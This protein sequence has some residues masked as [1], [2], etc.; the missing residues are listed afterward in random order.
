M[1]HFC[2]K[3]IELQCPG[4]IKPDRPDLHCLQRRIVSDSQNQPVVSSQSLPPIDPPE[5]RPNGDYHLLSALPDGSSL[6]TRFF[7]SV[8]TE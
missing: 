2:Q 4:G 5:V 3:T 7:P 1:S 6:E 8:V